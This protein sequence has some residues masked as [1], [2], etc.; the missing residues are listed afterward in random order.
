V[1]AWTSSFDDFSFHVRDFLHHFQ[2]SPAM[3]ALSEAPAL[4]AGRFAEGQIADAYLAAMAVELAHTLRQPRPAWTQAPERFC[5][6]PWF[7]TPGRSMRATLLLESPPG[8]RE[9]NLF[10]T[11][12]ALSVA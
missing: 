7:A 8:F 5:R 1:A 2:A 12:N 4:M 10:V 11:A 3:E 6:I 9:R